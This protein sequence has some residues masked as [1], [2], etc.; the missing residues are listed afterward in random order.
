MQ[1]SVDLAKSNDNN[2]VLFAYLILKKAEQR[3]ITM[4]DEAANYPSCR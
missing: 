2:A 4:R 3:L 1:L